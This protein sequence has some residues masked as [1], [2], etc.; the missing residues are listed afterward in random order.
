MRTGL[1]IS[2]LLVA[3]G[4]CGT[5]GS[6]PDAEADAVEPADPGAEADPVPDPAGE[7]VAVEVAPD[8]FGDVAPIV[9]PWCDPAMLGATPGKAVAI[10]DFFLPP[11]ETRPF[12]NMSLAVADP[13]AATG[14]RLAFEVHAMTP[15]L[16]QVDGFGLTAP[17]VVPLEGP[18]DPASLPAD[19][20]ASVAAGASVF[21][22]RTD[23]A[24]D[25]DLDAGR[26]AAAAVPVRAAWNED[27][28]S[29]VV[30]ASVTLAERSHYAL[31]VTRCVRDADGNPLSPA[32]AM[33][34]LASAPA[35][36]PMAAEMER[37]RR[38][39]ARPDVNLPAD[40]VAVAL[41][42]VTRTGRSRLAA[43]VAASKDADHHLAVD[44]A[45]KPTLPDGTLDPV[46]LAKI[47]GLKELLEDKLTKD[48]LAEYDFASIGTIAQGRITLRRYTDPVDGMKVGAG[49]APEP[50]EEIE[51]SFFLTLPAEDAAKG[52]VQPFP[53]IVYQH[54]FTVCKETAIAIAGSMSR[55]G[56]ATI[57]IDAVAH[58]SRAAGGWKCPIDPITF[59]TLGEPVRLWHN[60]AESVMGL[61]QLVDAAR[62]TP[63]DIVPAGGDGKPD[64]QTVTVGLLGQ[65]MG[66]FLGS[67]ALGLAQG[68]GPAVL[69]VGG[70]QLGL[71]FGWSML[72][73][74][75]DPLGVTFAGFTG[76]V[77][78]IMSAIQAALDDLEPMVLLPAG[79]ASEGAPRQVLIQQA[80][81]DDVVP[82]AC[83][84]RMARHLGVP[85]LS[86]PFL[87]LPGLPPVSAPVSDN[88][89]Q[90]SDGSRH[91]GA[92]T[93]FS[94]AEHA[95][96]LAR[97]SPWADPLVTLRGQAQAA[98]FV[99]SFFDDGVSKVIDPYDA[100]A[101]APY[102]PAGMAR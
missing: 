52:H 71:F 49:G 85:L 38:F 62:A 69:N 5:P 60:Y 81:Q 73:G 99:R 74:E 94:P 72:G 19:E 57:G 29:L 14:V 26:L 24:D 47:P 53:M 6:P 91:T 7:E 93:E 83:G 100:G 22:V 28:A 76:M 61:V 32:P 21:L 102:L 101:I 18:P 63:L 39:L 56:L 68:V 23:G 58:G 87:A 30:E 3:V 9:A 34:A 43:A 97:D 48:Q 51:V 50:F 70:G 20:A 65:S 40:A 75:S 31:I 41:P 33:A 37:T 13:A 46:F 95:F 77:L 89:H 25:P 36:S 96:L 4:S 82:M 8:G 15:L 54:A 12:P 11:A 44:W 90:A 1:L 27:A 2:I 98:A 86:P 67:G 59:L 45:M 10:D 84:H 17:F 79:W 64:W 66:T 92:M 78:D 80:V 35:A 42:M 55:A 88:F 16:N